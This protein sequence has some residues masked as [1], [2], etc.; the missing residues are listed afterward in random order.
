[1]IFAFRI[2]L[3][4]ISACYEQVQIHNIQILTSLQLQSNLYLVPFFIWGV[5]FISA[6]IVICG[7]LIC[8][9]I[10]VFAL[11]FFVSNI[12]PTRQRLT[13]QSDVFYF[14]VLESKWTK[15]GETDFQFRRATFSLIIKEN[16]RTALPL[17]LGS[18]G[19][20][21]LRVRGGTT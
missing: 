10:S 6:N 19:L 5:T 11:F 15:P 13:L 21:A 3:F 4:S 2:C 12:C 18:I 7:P 16:Y 14:S 20:Q 17:I 9:D 1:M 8:I